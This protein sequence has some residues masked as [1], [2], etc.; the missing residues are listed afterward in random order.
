MFAN[1]SVFLLIALLSWLVG[2]RY[3]KKHPKEKQQ[4]FTKEKESEMNGGGENAHKEE[5]D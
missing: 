2:Y 3:R 5:N 4:K 1:N